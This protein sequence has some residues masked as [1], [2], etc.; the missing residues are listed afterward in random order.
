[1]KSI[2]SKTRLQELKIAISTARGFIFDM[3]GTILD[4]HEAHYHA[5]DRVTRDYGFRYEKEEIV[6]QFGKTTAAIAAIL[7]ET[8]DPATIQ[9]ISNAK[10][11]YFIDEIPSIQLFEG[12]VD[13]F[14][15]LKRLEKRICIASSNNNLAIEKII[16][17][18]QMEQLVDGFIGL[19][20]ITRGKPDPEMIVKS[21]AKLDLDPGDCIVIGDT[22]YDMQAAVTAG[23]RH[24][25]G[26][27]TGTTMADSLKAA[28]ASAVLQSVQQFLAIV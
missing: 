5:W 11:G 9:E 3:D 7:C 4:S 24:A 2:T 1:M 21:A 27:L 13:V 26:V 10:E 19:D 12:V 6:A 22:I 14:A 25:I 16:E 18:F 15:A 23:V 17:Q 20:D 8:S 28:G